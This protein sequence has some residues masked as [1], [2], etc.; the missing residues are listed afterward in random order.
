MSSTS[1]DCSPATQ[2]HRREATL[3]DSQRLSEPAVSGRLQT[4]P[5][6]A[7]R[8]PSLFLLSEAMAK[9]EGRATDGRTAE[10]LSYGF[11]PLSP[12]GCGATPSIRVALWHWPLRT[13]A[14]CG[15][16]PQ[17]TAARHP[18]RDRPSGDSPCV[19]GRKFRDLPAASAQA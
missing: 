8:V 4:S 7:G 10:A 19:R 13:H 11:S 3:S 18:A 12:D 15:V 14:P 9:Q 16:F 17:E 6:I 1:A 2:L 5:K